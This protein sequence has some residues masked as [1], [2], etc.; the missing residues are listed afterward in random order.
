MKCLLLL[1][2]VA[3]ATGFH[4]QPN[5]IARSGGDTQ[6]SVSQFQ[7][8][9]EY[10]FY[11]RTEVHPD[12]G[13]IRS[14]YKPETMGYAGGMKPYEQF[15]YGTGMEKYG[16]G[17][18][19]YGMGY[20]RSGG[21]QYNQPWQYGQQFRQGQQYGQTGQQYGQTGQQYG[22]TGQQHGQTGQQYGQTGQQ[23]GQTGQQY[24]QQYP[25]TQY[26]QTQYPQTQYPQKPYYQTQYP[27]TYGTP[28]RTET[29]NKPTDYKTYGYKPIEKTM[30]G[31]SYPMYRAENKD[32][33]LESLEVVGENFPYEKVYV[34]KY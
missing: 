27:K 22:Q 13:K 21:Q 15:K 3:V 14:D 28:F 4:Q 7:K 9:P 32:V 19:K 29:Y 30:Y 26:P 25:Q 1:C 24:G 10:T 2:A 5:P 18:E 12:Q 11:Y 6:W 17:F 23:Y 8:T 33:S 34:V 20:Q 31:K 16:K